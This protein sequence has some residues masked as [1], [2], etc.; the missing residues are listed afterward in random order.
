LGKRTDQ[1]AEAV[2]AV[3]PAGAA[4]ATAPVE[5]VQGVLDDALP[6]MVAG[7]GYET[8]WTDFEALLAAVQAADTT[9]LAALRAIREQYE[10]GPPLI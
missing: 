5:W 2:L 3:F 1:A 4:F 7:A 10:G 6:D 8:V 9:V